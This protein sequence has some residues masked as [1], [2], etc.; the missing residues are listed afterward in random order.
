M[1]VEW[2]SR[3]QLKEKGEQSVSKYRCTGCEYV[4]DEE[5]GDVHEGYPPGTV[6]ETLPEEFTC[7]DCA[8]RYKEDFE[9]MPEQ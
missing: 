4:Y 5:A 8:V 2:R 6:F 9:R 1:A 7:P 3:L